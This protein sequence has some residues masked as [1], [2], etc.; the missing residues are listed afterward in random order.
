MNRDLLRRLVVSVSMIACLVGTAY[1]VGLIGTRVEE[2]SGGSLAADA[3]LIAPAVRAF[4]IWSV[5]Y[6][7]LIA[8]VVWQWL[9]STATDQRARDTGMLAAASMILN[10]A[11]LGVTQ[12]GWL[13]A[14]VAVI[15]VLEVV[16]ARLVDLLG[17]T[18]ARSWG[19]RIVVDGTFGL[20]LGWVSVATCANIAATLVAQGVTF[21][22]ADPWIASAVLLV[23]G[24]VGWLL[25]SRLGGRWAV[26]AA[27]AWGLGWIAVG[28]LTDEPRS[29]VVA[30]AAGVAAAAVL[31]AAGLV[32]RS[33]VP[34]AA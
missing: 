11:W 16:L 27:M 32:R 28:R 10:A 4:S 25:A 2:S 30:I 18:P 6:L 7:G 34:V 8:Y 31:A 17:R 3:T 24:G 14:S 9:P 15:V 22:G 20:Y 21:G 19:E 12:V 26:A 13:W 5:I 1:G 33:Q 29:L 23:A